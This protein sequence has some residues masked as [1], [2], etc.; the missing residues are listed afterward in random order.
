MS[1]RTDGLAP[2]SREFWEL[3]L[4]VDRSPELSEREHGALDI[5][6]QLFGQ[7]HGQRSKNVYSDLLRL[8]LP[9]EAALDDI[10]AA[11]APRNSAIRVMTQELIMRRRAYWA[12]S[13]DEWKDVLGSTEG[14]FHKRN[15]CHGNC[16]QYVMAI[17]YRLGGFDR[18]EDVGT[19]NQYRMALKVFGRKE[20]DAAGEQVR[21]EMRSVGFRSKVPRG[22]KQALYSALLYQRSGRLE[23]ITVKTLRRVASS[24]VRSMRTG[25]A[26]LSRVLERLGMIEQGFCLRQGE[27]RRPAGER[28]A[29][30]NVPDE[31]LGWCDRWRTTATAAPSSVTSN[32]YGILK[33]GRWLGDQHPDILSPAQWD[34][35]LALEYAS[36]V[37][38]MRIGDWSTPFGPVGARTGKPLKPAAVASHLRCVRAFFNDLQ[39]WEWIAPRFSPAQTLVPSRAIR[40]KIGPAPRVIADDIW[41][42]LIWAALNL[43]ENDLRDRSKREGWADQP[44]RYPLAMVRAVAILWLFGGLR[45]DEIHRMRVGAIRWSPAPD[46]ES[47]FPTCL[48]DV[49]VNKTSRAFTKPVDSIVGTTI[50][51]WEAERLPHPQSIDN[52]TGERV[53]WLFVY[54]GRRMAPAYINR[55]LIPI[56]CAKGGV[57]ET[58]ARGR[59]T[60][61]RAR[62]TIATQLFN[63]KEPLSLFE[64]QAWLG[65]TSPHATQYYAAITPTKLAR[66]FDRA[67]YFERNVRTIEVLIDQAARRTSGDGP[68]EPWQYYDLGHGYCTYDFF[69]QCA[70]RMACAK[71]SFYEPKESARMQALEAQGNLKRMLQEIPLTETEREAVEDGGR[72]MATLAASL[73]RVPTPDGR[74]RQRIEARNQGKP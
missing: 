1:M 74:L 28:K 29:I 17:A 6:V 26:T 13:Q 65:H 32:Y 62:A 2:A 70:H 45:R 33:C 14:T 57:P 64:L 48:L 44:L 38:K 31:W 20:V 53:D 67:G 43:T 19:F 18:L 72:L 21:D 27:R 4:P 16:R 7:P 8:L 61:H 68:A 71:C 39:E 59:I 69:D 11:P 35:A 22:V 47:G 42:K 52:K 23:D 41:A 58:D 36:S 60:S 30:E 55:A 40:A 12:W 51:G 5:L 3:A 50:K 10:K 54:K 56:L 34:R 66:S 73:E 15:G 49:P 37:M 9:L 46:S 24:D 63:A 25:A